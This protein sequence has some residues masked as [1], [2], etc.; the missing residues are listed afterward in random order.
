MTCQFV[1]VLSNFG[2]ELQFETMVR[3]GPGVPVTIKS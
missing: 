3:I 2:T 1:K